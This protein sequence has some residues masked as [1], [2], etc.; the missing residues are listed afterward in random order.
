MKRYKMG[1]AQSRR[2]FTRTAKSVHPKNAPA[3]PMR[4]GI[5]L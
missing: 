1:N 3:A 4:G 2:L 5:R